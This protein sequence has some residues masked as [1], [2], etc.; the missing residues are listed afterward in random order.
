MSSDIVPSVKIVV[1]T[2]THEAHGFYIRGRF[3]ELVEE[4]HKRNQ[5]KIIDE[6]GIGCWY[7][8]ENFVKSKDFNET[9]KTRKP[10]YTGPFE[11]LLKIDRRHAKD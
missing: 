10:E 3:Y 8:W 9:M 4:D 5:I 2:A 11:S 7:T 1:A 6:R